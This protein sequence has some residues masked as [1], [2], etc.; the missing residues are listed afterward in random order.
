MA[1][2]QHAVSCEYCGSVCRLELAPGGVGSVDCATCQRK[3]F[4]RSAHSIPE[5]ELFGESSSIDSFRIP[6]APP[7]DGVAPHLVALPCVQLTEFT[8]S[9]ARG[10]PVGM[11]WL[12]DVLGGPGAE[13]VSAHDSEVAA[14]PPTSRSAEAL[15]EPSAD[16]LFGDASDEATAETSG[17]ASANTSA[18]AA[19]QN[20]TEQNGTEQNGTERLATA[21]LVD[22]LMEQQRDEMRK[23]GWKKKPSA[24][25]RPKSTKPSARDPKK[26]SKM[27]KPSEEGVAA[28]EVRTFAPD[29]SD[30]EESESDEEDSTCNWAQCDKCG[31]WR[32]LP[33]EDAFAPEATLPTPPLPHPLPLP[34]TPIPLPTPTP[35][36]ILPTWHKPVLPMYSHVSCFCQF[37]QPELARRVVLPHEPQHAAEHMRQARREDGQ[38]GDMG[39]PRRREGGG[40]G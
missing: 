15:P 4:A 19:A 40:G 3:L 39:G 32:R 28:V 26:A 22:A 29:S 30:D 34:P 9:D 21:L 10:H 12:C 18:Q 38:A 17:D 2:S 6:Q 31:K 25:K 16:Q 33:L 14:A 11:E 13:E 36:P 5:Q 35:T 24:P 20:G 8:L 7:A 23:Q 37:S 1:M 27:S